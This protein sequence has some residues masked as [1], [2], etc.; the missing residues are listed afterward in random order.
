MKRHRRGSL[1]PA[2]FVAAGSSYNNN[3]NKQSKEG[4]KEGLTA[5]D[6]R[7]W[8]W[9][10]WL[11]LWPSNLVLK[12]TQNVLSSE[13]APAMSE[14]EVGKVQRPGRC[15][16]T[17]YWRWVKAVHCAVRWVVQV[18]SM[19]QSHVMQTILCNPDVPTT[20]L[21]RHKIHSLELWLLR[22]TERTIV[23]RCSKRTIWFCKNSR[24]KRPLFAC[25]WVSDRCAIL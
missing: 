4:V 13:V 23:L 10:R 22:M 1:A 25:P 8:V 24:V 19:C 14:F 17:F 12:W 5:M 2:P 21:Q 15:P 11:N 20:Q 6:K 3:N 16:P 9:Q 7:V 18:I